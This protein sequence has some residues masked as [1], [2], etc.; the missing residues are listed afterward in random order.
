[1]TVWSVKNN[2]FVN[3]RTTTAGTG[4][5]YGV[6]YNL[7]T[8]VSSDYNDIHGTGT[9]FNYGS[10][11]G[12]AYASQSAFTA[13][14]AGFEA[15]SITSDPLYNSATTLVPDLHVSGSSPVNAVGTA[16]SNT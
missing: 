10:V 4:L 13:A 15:N 16:S 3:S 9:A 2:I 8:N 14:N 6:Y 12:T 11:G 7:S 5:N 1:M